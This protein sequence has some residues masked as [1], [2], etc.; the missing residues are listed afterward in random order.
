MGLTDD[1]LYSLIT[2]Q[3]K[4]STVARVI[5]CVYSNEKRQWQHW[6]KILKHQ[7][8]L[9]A[10]KNLS[11]N[12]AFPNNPTSHQPFP[13]PVAKQHGL[14]DLKRF[15]IV[16]I[17]LGKPRADPFPSMV[18]NPGPKKLGQI[19]ELPP[20]THHVWSS[21]SRIT[22]FFFRATCMSL[23]CGRCFLPLPVWP[24]LAGPNAEIP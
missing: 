11:Q 20:P 1:L 2:P 3:P 16:W 14:V 24:R 4:I 13:P 12:V 9:S 15:A 22:R 6:G 5:E 17:D 7:H 10:P 21:G 23:W 8:R 19:A 18:G